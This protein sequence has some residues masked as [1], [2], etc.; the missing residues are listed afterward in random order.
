MAGRNANNFF[1]VNT[2]EELKN[3][4]VMDN[5]VFYSFLKIRGFS[6]THDIPMED[7]YPACNLSNNYVKLI[8]FSSG[9]WPTNFWTA[10]VKVRNATNFPPVVA[11]AMNVLF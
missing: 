4:Q 2:H 6:Q 9:S 5:F 10:A 8:Y 1:V 7:L 11:K 3:V